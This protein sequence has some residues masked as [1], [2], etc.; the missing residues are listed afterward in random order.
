MAQRDQDFGDVFSSGSD[1]TPSDLNTASLPTQRAANDE[2][3]DG[4]D[5]Q[6]TISG[7]VA[8]DERRIMWRYWIYQQLETA[9]RAAT[10]AAVAVIDTL[11]GRVC[12]WSLPVV[13]VVVKVIVV[14]NAKIK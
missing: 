4:W 2:G 14:A 1:F 7:E 6:Y 13:V 11:S 10:A 5:R 9:S 12:V 3:G 8:A